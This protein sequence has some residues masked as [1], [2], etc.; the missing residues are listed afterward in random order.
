[1]VLSYRANGKKEIPNPTVP[2]D[3]TFVSPDAAMESPRP[4]T[5]TLGIGRTEIGS[6]SSGPS[7]PPSRSVSAAGSVTG[8]VE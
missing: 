2:A 7:A 3:D 8:L 1:M 5:G 4:P 6:T